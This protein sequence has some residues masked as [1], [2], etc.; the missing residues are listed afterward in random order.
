MGKLDDNQ[1]VGSDSGSEGEDESVQQVLELLGKG[2]VYNFGPEGKQTFY[3]VPP[4]KK[5]ET[6][7]AVAVNTTTLPPLT[8]PKTSKFKVDRSQAGPP[9]ADQSQAKSVSPSPTATFPTA[10]AVV[11]RRP[12]GVVKTTSSAGSSP[13]PSTIVDPTSFPVPTSALSSEARKPGPQLSMIDSPSFRPPQNYVPSTPFSMIVESPSFLRLGDAPQ[14]KPAS[15]ASM[16]SQAASCQP[17]A[18]RRPARPPAV[19]SSAVREK[20]NQPATEGVKPTLSTEPQPKAKKV[21]RFLAE[22]T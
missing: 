7:T 18:P 12:P 19:M 5:A 4:P 14:S 2:E 8:K 6:D 17:T 22:R 11:E 10:A 21:S 9:K 13:I 15:A 16:P 3:A 20:P 1:L